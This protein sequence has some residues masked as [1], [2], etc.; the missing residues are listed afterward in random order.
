MNICRPVTCPPVVVLCPLFAPRL[1][2]IPRQHALPRPCQ[3]SVHPVPARVTLPTVTPAAATTAPPPGY[4]HKSRPL[5]WIVVTIPPSRSP[6]LRCCRLVRCCCCEWC[7]PRHMS[8]RA[9]VCL[10]VICISR[11]A[12]GRVGRDSARPVLPPPPPRLP[13][14]LRSSGQ[15]CD[16]TLCSAA[17]PRPSAGRVEVVREGIKQPSAHSSD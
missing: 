17:L 15:C 16:S 5:T 4:I 7:V 3:R 12:S 1:T 6:L 9:S 13:G 14:A 10:L 2:Q 11:P 8:L